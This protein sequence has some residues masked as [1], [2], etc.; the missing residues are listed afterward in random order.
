MGKN[1]K[2]RLFERKTG[3]KCSVYQIGLIW[4][5]KFLKR[6]RFLH[7]FLCHLKVHN[8]S[9]KSRKFEQNISMGLGDMAI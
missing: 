2:N 3:F 9:V 4:K 1:C 7:S 8:N 5:V 6:V